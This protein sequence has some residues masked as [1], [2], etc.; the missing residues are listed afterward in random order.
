MGFPYG[1]RLKILRIAEIS[2]VN[3][4]AAGAGGGATGGFAAA[5]SSCIRRKRIAQPSC[6]SIAVG[7]YTP[8]ATNFPEAY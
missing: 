8:S 7:S 5:W 3:Q 6:S 2:E 4:F 1:L